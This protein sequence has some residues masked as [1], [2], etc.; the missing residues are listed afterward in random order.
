VAIVATVAALIVAS[1]FLPVREW[2]EALLAWVEGLGVIGAVVFGLAYVV[3][4]VAFLPGSILTLGSGFVY[5]VLWGTVIVSLSST[6]GAAIAFLVGRFFARDF[7]SERLEDYPRFHAVD[8]AI[9]KEGFRVVLLTRLSPIFPFNLLNYA[10]GVTGVSF[11]KYV[12]A[13]WIGMLPGTIMYVYLGSAAENLARIVAGEV[14][15]GLGQQILFGVGLVATIA[16]A[17][18]ITRKARSELEEITGGL[19]EDADASEP[20]GDGAGD[21][22]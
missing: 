9:E 14:E 19:D 17:V 7:V 16:V 21:D 11:G 15:A 4:T 22:A 1:Q 20:D 18:S 13:S 8:R 10:F 5:G 3:A 12:L 6:L 2:L